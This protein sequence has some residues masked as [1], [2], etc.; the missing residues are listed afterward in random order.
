MLFEIIST[1]LMG[2]IALK[3]YSEHKGMATKESGKIQRILSLA[4]LN[5]HDGKNTLTTQLVKKKRQEWGWEYKFRIPLGRCFEDYLAKVN[6]IED[7]LNNR[8]KRISIDDLKT[9][10]LQ[11]DILSNFK[12]MWKEKLTEQKEIELDY[13]GLLIIRVY[14]KPM[15]KK[16]QFVAGEGWRVPVGITRAQN[17]FKY[18]DFEIVPHITLGGATRYGKSN[19]I[20]SMICSLLHSNADNVN[21]FL[22]DLKGGVELCDYENIQQTI[23]IAYEPNEALETLQLAYNRMRSIQSELRKIGKKNVQEAGIKERYFV[24]VDEVGELNPLEAV[25]KEEK[26]LKQQCQTIMSQI[27]RLGAGLGFRQVLATQYPT[28][29]VIPRQCKQNSDA[30][31][32]F[33]VQSAT[34]SRVVLDETGAELL[35]QIKGRAIYQTA[36]NR[37]I[38]QTPFITSDEI[39]SIILPFQVRK[40]KINEKENTIEQGRKDIVT[41]TTV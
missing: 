1:G 10:E 11:G 9:L 38:L 34:A 5:V 31:L 13:D 16:V 8:R 40:E 24:I 19:F 4:G 27:A 37:E 14:D 2:G 15:S 17:E 23:S 6:V 39:K 25:T 20:N 18:H 36:D 28:G 22:I 29:D 21:L 41:F 7:G 3:A 33:R 30:K 26:Q 32:S 12:K 35:P